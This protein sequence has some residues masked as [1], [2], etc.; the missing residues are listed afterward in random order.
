M[1][2]EIYDQFE[3]ES[4]EGEDF[5]VI[6]TERKN[7]RGSRIKNIAEFFE[8]TEHHKEFSQWQTQEVDFSKVKNLSEILVSPEEFVVEVESIGG[9]SLSVS[10]KIIV[11]YNEWNL[12]DI[13]WEDS[14]RYYRRMW[15]TTA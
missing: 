5:L 15:C 11:R 1:K 6:A 2:L 4:W 3:F 14:E 12:L 8:R 9:L 13:L 7:L 10:Q